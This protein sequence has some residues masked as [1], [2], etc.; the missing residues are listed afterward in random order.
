MEY[1]ICQSCRDGVS[2]G[3]SA[4]SKKSVRMFLE[5]EIAWDARI[6]EFMLAADLTRRFDACIACRTAR[7]DCAGYGIS[8]LFDEGG[9]ITVGP[10]PLMIC[11][12]CIGR[13]T[14]GLSEKSRDAWR[15]FLADHFSGP[16]G[17]WESFPGSGY[18]GML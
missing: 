9:M 13:M 6:M 17:D 11:L 3:F 2:A 1:A 15:R 16:P 14:E 18:P 12:P 10:L 8:A 7:E 4:A 5:T